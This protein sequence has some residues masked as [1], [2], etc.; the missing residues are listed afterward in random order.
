MTSFGAQFSNPSN[1]KLQASTNEVLYQL[2]KTGSGTTVAN[3]GTSTN[4]SYLSVPGSMAN[5]DTLKIKLTK[6]GGFELYS[7]SRL[8]GL[9]GAHDV[10]II[11]MARSADGAVYSYTPAMEGTAQWR[12]TLERQKQALAD[13][14]KKSDIEY[15][16]DQEP[17][18]YVVGVTV[19]GE[20]NIDKL[21][22]LS[23]SQQRDVLSV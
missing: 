5:P 10:T 8:S 14:L 13:L 7:P 18:G 6:G 4:P 23:S 3:T 20:S 22:K 1:G 11:H 2:R 21:I 19:T 17:G 16:L 12:N 9:S 15:R